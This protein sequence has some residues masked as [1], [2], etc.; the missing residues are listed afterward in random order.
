MPAL[1]RRRDHNVPQECWRVYYGDVCTPAPLRSVSAT[2]S[3]LP[4]GNGAAASIPVA[5]RESAPAAPPLRSRPLAKPLRLR[6][7]YFCRTEARPTSRRGAISR[8]GPRRNID[9]SIAANECRQLGGR[10]RS[11]DHVRLLHFDRSVRL[12]PAVIL[13]RVWLGRR[14]RRSEIEGLW[15]GLRRVMARRDVC[16]A[17]NGRT[18]ES[19]EYGRRGE[20][21]FTCHRS[22]SL[23]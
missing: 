9:G 15:G 23:V 12:R 3:L 13:I 5:G 17:S 18:R 6:G 2:P 10:R 20:G 21:N 7:A 11:P 4:N 19:N 14:R 16:S 1:T 22:V 8:L